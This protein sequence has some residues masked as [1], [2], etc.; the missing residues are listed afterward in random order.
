MCW[1]GP[2][3]SWSCFADACQTSLPR[4]RMSN[5]PA[6]FGSCLEECEP[7]PSSHGRINEENTR[8]V[9]RSSALGIPKAI[10]FLYSY[11]PVTPPCLAALTTTRSEFSISTS[12]TLSSSAVSG[13]P[14][15]PSCNDTV[16][17]GKVANTSSSASSFALESIATPSRKCSSRRFYLGAPHDEQGISDKK[18]PLMTEG[19]LRDVSP[20]CPASN[21]LR[22]RI[23]NVRSFIPLENSGDVGSLRRGSRA[24]LG[25]NLISDK[26]RNSSMVLSGLEGS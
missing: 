3:R 6:G 24:C 4:H 23:I 15:H 12:Q 5:F 2:L 22:D 26:A 17:I 20:K 9:T 16:C 1:V 10:L 18:S 13:L 14:M 7:A 8:S 11:L 19:S 21:V 25:T